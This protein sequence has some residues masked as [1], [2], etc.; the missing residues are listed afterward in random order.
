MKS[1]NQKSLRTNPF[2]AYRDPLSGRWITVMTAKQYQQSTEPWAFTPQVRHS[3]ARETI[4]TANH[5][6]FSTL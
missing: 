1:S 6:S 2:W 3:E 5:L 4:S